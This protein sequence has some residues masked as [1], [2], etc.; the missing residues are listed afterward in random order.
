MVSDNASIFTNEEFKYFCRI[1]GI[2][3]KFIA[4]GHPEKNGLAERNVQTLKDKLKLMSSENL[5]M[6]L[7]VQRIIFRYR[8]TT[9]ASGK[10]P[11]E[12]YLNRQ[13]RIKLDAMF[14]HYEMA[15]E[16]KI[17]PRTRMI[18]VGERVRTK[19]FVNNKPNWKR[20]I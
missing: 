5:P 18:K 3:Q 15:S 4:P 16:Q 12:M 2:K 7:K 8:T 19:F 13:I 14:P 1:N 11:A 17:K 9:L 6:H 10:S 20:G